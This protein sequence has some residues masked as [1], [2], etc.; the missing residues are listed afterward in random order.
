MIFSAFCWCQSLNDT[1][2][3]NPIPGLIP[4]INSR[5]IPA[6]SRWERDVGK[7]PEKVR[8]NPENWKMDLELWNFYHV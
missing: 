1:S 8:K 7:V 5:S 3:K 4:G 2:L 6:Q